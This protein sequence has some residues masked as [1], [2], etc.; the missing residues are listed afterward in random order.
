MNKGA[1]KE[2]MN[3]KVKVFIFA[4]IIYGLIGNYILLIV[5]F[6]LTSLKSGRLHKLSPDILNPFVYIGS[7]NIDLFF[8]QFF[9]LGNI[10]ILVFP[11]YLA[12]VYEPKGKIMQTGL[13]KVTDQI[14]IPVPAGSGQFGR[15][16][17][18]TYEDLDNTKEIKE[19]VYQKSQKKV[20][21]K[22]GIVIGI[23]AIGDIPSKSGAE[24]I[25]CIC[26]DRHILLVGATRSGKSR[27]I[28][29]ESIWF[30]LKAGENMLINDPKGELYAYTSPF[31]K[32]NGYQ[33]VA[34]DFR[35]PNKGTHYN[36]MEE[37]ISAIDSG[38]VAEAVDLTWD[39]VSVLVGD[40]KGEPIWHNGECATI[41]A[42]ILIVATEAPKEY[43]NL[44]NV[45]YFLANM[46]KP[47]PFGEMPITR[48]LSGLD[49]THPAKAVFAMAEIAHPKTRGSFFS[50]ALGT[51]KHFTNPKIAEMT[52]YTDYTFEQMA[53]EKTIVY[54]ILPDEKKT[55]YSLASI[56]IMQQVIYNTKVANENGG[57]CPIDWWYIL[58]EFGQ[59]PYIPPFPQ[60]T[61]VGAGRGMRFLIA[62]QGFQQLHKV[63]K[64][65]DNTIKNNCDAWI[66]LKCS[67]EETLK[68]FSTRCGNY[69]VQVNSTNFNEKNSSNGNGY[70]ASLTGRPLLMPDEVGL[71]ESP[72]CLISMAGKHPLMLITPDLSYYFANSELGLGDPSYNR[73][74]MSERLSNREERKI[75][76]ILLWGIWKDFQEISEDE[77]ET[78]D[79]GYG[80]D[81]SEKVSFLD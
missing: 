71:I 32:D 23:H 50:S 58:D 54:I 44:T 76:N 29:L 19:F 7:C 42:S 77:Y 64:D 27:R 74:V 8:W 3:K 21:D 12:F 38:N 17:F 65:D 49:D 69:T 73:K 61:S 72:H 45:Y 39:L 6:I 15:Q 26:E 10:L 11:V 70:G 34:I 78:D 41:A 9:I 46:A 36:Y 20:P 5:Y 2:E 81:E 57:R 56:Y 55:L 52:G 62:L 22:G 25:M 13:I 24:H 16:R 48:Y 75:E 30:T 80:G 67:T 14:S 18:M 79:Y 28:I 1:G 66:Y 37:I 53:H 63:Y 4:E 47:D 59:M 60:F 68:A 40:L 31:A 35:N 43:R 51:L 33:V